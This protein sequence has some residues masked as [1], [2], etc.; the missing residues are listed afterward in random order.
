MA[1]CA[2]GRTPEPCHGL[3]SVGECNLCSCQH[4][5]HLLPAA[6]YLLHFHIKSLLN[7]DFFEDSVVNLDGPGLEKHIYQYICSFVLAVD[8]L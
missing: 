4:Q 2:T 1:R 8:L 5:C 7:T 6:G 3:S